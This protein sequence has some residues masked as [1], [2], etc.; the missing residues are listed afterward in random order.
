M[1]FPRLYRLW[2]YEAGGCFTAVK[3]HIAKCLDASLR[4]ERL[5]ADRRRVR[6]S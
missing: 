1:K 6:V 4:S 5:T 2:I 3:W